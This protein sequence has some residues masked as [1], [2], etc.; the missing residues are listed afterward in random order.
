LAAGAFLGVIG[1]GIGTGI[2]ALIP[3]RKLIYARSPS[4][5]GV[6]DERDFTSL[7]TR[8]VTVADDT[9]TE[10]TGSLVSLTADE[11]TVRTNGQDRSFARERVAAIFE[12]GDSVKNGLSI[13]FVTG[14]SLGM[15][16]GVSKTQCGRNNVGIGLI[17]AY[18]SYTPCSVNERIS[19][20]LSEGVLAGVIGLGLGTAIDA[21]I[22]G[23]REIYRRPV[24][25]PAATVSIAPSLAPS[26]VG[27][28]MSVSW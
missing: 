11:V 15:A 21:M 28:L 6:R 25:T 9:G 10:T 13:G 4:T 20:G 26:R 3:G 23:R 19:Q 24:T 16:A 18:L 22:P 1:L 17:T 12:R 8:P 5:T 7:A 14:F 2:D 27:L